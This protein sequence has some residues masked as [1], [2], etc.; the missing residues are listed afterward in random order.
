MAYHRPSADRPTSWTVSPLK[1]T[2]ICGSPG[3]PNTGVSST[4][5]PVVSKPRRRPTRE[6]AKTTPEP[7]STTPTT[8]AIRLAE[9]TSKRRRR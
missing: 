7:R 6:A 1:M 3:Q 5:V 9:T 4:T 2:P 8:M